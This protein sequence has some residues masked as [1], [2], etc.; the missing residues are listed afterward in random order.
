[1]SLSTSCE[2]TGNGVPTKK[3]RVTCLAKADFHWYN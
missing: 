3:Q 1:M 2:L